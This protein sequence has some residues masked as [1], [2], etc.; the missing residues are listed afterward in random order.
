MKLKNRQKGFV[1]FVVIAAL[2]VSTLIGGYLGFKLGD[3]TFF[4]IGVGLGVVLVFTMIFWTP[5]K[6]LVDFISSDKNDY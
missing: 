6:R 2:I 5:L 1:P 3:G 4:S